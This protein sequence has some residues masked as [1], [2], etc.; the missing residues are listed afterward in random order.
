MLCFQ[1]FFWIVNILISWL[2]FLFFELNYGASQRS[3]F[4]IKFTRYWWCLCIFTNWSLKVFIWLCCRDY[5]RHKS[6]LIK[7]NKI[8]ILSNN[9]H[10]NIWDKINYRKNTW[11]FKVLNKQKKSKFITTWRSKYW[12]RLSSWNMLTSSFQH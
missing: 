4:L 12:I 8:I 3:S 6:L 7:I 10:F 1:L 2:L 11:Y 9:N 5:C